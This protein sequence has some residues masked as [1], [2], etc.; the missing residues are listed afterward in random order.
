VTASPSQPGSN[1]TGVPPGSTPHA[2]LF[3][4]EWTQRVTIAGSTMNE[5]PIL[6]PYGLTD[7][8]VL[9]SLGKPK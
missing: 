3:Y 8:P 6:P 2:Q 9:S 4:V 7:E 1:T 5:G